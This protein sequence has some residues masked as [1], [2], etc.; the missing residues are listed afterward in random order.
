MCALC[1]VS[2]FHIK[3]NCFFFLKKI[4]Y[5]FPPFF[6]SGG[7]GRAVQT[8]SD[9]EGACPVERRGPN[10]KY[11]SYQVISCFSTLWN[12]WKTWID[13]PKV[14]IC[15]WERGVNGKKATVNKLLLRQILTGKH[16]RSQVACRD[17]FI[18]AW[19]T[20]VV[21]SLIP[22]KPQR[23]STKEFIRLWQTICTELC[24][25]AGLSWD[26]GKCLIHW[27]AS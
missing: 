8:I 22:T 9:Q 16:S 15:T 5:S 27:Q 12:A 11:F 6:F 14:L 1:W 21:S 10:R 25:L 7:G 26:S 23:T 17:W 3:D 4:I 24:V 18:S 2:S 20:N 19:S 13:V